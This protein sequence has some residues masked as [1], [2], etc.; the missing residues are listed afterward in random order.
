MNRFSRRPQDNRRIRR[1]TSQPNRFRNR[2]TPLTEDNIKSFDVLTGLSSHSTP[3]ANN[4]PPPEEPYTL[5]LVDPNKE[6]LVEKYLKDQERE[7]DHTP[8]ELDD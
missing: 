5:G 7:A 8:M 2:Q 3:Q 1:N 6:R 4:S